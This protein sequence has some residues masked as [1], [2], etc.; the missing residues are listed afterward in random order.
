[1]AYN[2]AAFDCAD[3]AMPTRSSP[4]TRKLALIALVSFVFSAGVLRTAP[5]DAQS[6][7]AA[8]DLRF[9]AALDRAANLPRLHSL[10]VSHAG[11][12]V[13]EEYYHV[14][15]Q[16]NTGDLTRTSYLV[17]WVR[18]GFDGYKISYE[19]EARGFVAD[20]VQEYQ[21]LLGR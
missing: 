13:L 3:S 6:A 7:E 17:E 14:I 9:D 19:V 12:L 21:R 16:W 5:A 8:I 2:G 11:E 20:N 10:L 4:P 1:M 18:V 15:G